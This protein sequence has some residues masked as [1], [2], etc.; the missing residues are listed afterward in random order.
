MKKRFLIVCFGL[1]VVCLTFAM[2]IFSMAPNTMQVYGDEAADVSILSSDGQ[3]SPQRS[4][5][6]LANE[7][8]DFSTKYDGEAL[9]SYYS[10]RDEYMLYAQQQS[11]QGLCW[12]FAS[13]M[14]LSTTIMKK[15]GE[16]LDFSE[17]W[18]SLAITYGTAS[19][20]FTEY[21]NNLSSSYYPGDG[22]WFLGFDL[23]AKRYGVLLEQEFSF[24]QSYLT[25]MSN[26]NS[27]YNEYSQYANKNIMQNVTAGKFLNYQNKDTATRNLTL[28][29][30]KQHIK[31]DGGV[32]IALRWNSM[33]TIN[34]NGKDL[35]FKTPGESTSAGHL[36][37]IIGWDDN[38]T[39]TYNGKTYKGAWIVLNSWGNEVY[40]TL[41]DRGI[42]YIF[43]DDSNLDSHLWAYEYN[44]T[45]TDDDLYLR[46]NIT[47]SNATYTTKHA[48]EYYGNFVA[49]SAET[50]QKNIFHNID[51]VN[52]VYEY[53][54]SSMTTLSKAEIFCK[55]EDVTNNFTV[56]YG[57]NS[58][59]ING[60]DVPLGAYQVVFTYTNGTTTEQAE[61]CFYV[62]D[63]TETNYAYYSIGA[64]AANGTVTN[65][66]KYLNYNNFNY[67]NE[68]YLFATSLSSG[69]L[70]FKLIFATY[71][72]IT[73]VT[74]NTSGLY[75]GTLKNEQIWGTIYFDLSTATT[76]S[77]TIRTSKGKTK[78]L[79]VKFV[80]KTNSTDEWANVFYETNGGKNNAQNER[81]ELVSSTTGAILE[82]PT[83]QGYN[84]AGW[85][86]DKE[87]TTKLPQSGGKYYIEKQMLNNTNGAVGW[88]MSDQSVYYGKQVFV[89]VYAKWTK[90]AP[91]GDC[92]KI[93]SGGVWNKY[94][95]LEDA[96]AAAADSDV[97]FLTSDYVLEEQIVLDKHITIV[98][99]N[100]A[101]LYMGTGV[102]GQE[103]IYSPFT[104]NLTLGSDVSTINGLTLTKL[105]ID[106]DS[107]NVS[108]KTFFTGKTFATHDN[109][110]VQNFKYTD[111]L[112]SAS[113]IKI[114]GGTIQDN[115]YNNSSSEI[116]SLCS[117]NSTI[118]ING[119]S[120]VINN[121]MQ[122]GNANLLYA[123]TVTL[124]QNITISGNETASVICVSTFYP[125]GAVIKNN[126]VVYG[127]IYAHSKSID[128]RN[129]TI[130]SEVDL[131]LGYTSGEVLVDSTTNISTIELSASIDVKYNIK[132]TGTLLSSQKFSILF[133]NNKLKA[134]YLIKDGDYPLITLENGATISEDNIKFVLNSK[135]PD[136]SWVVS[137][138]YSLARG[139]K[140]DTINNYYIKAI[141]NF[142]YNLNYTGATSV[143][144][145]YEFGET[146]T[147][148]EQPTRAG[149]EF[150]GWYTTSALTTLYTFGTMPASDVTVYAKW[151]QLTF[152][153]VAS[154]TEGGTITPSG[155]VNKRYNTRQK[156]LFSPSTGYEVKNI[157]VDGVALTGT[158]LTDAIA[159]GYTFKL[160]QADHTIHVEFVATVHTFTF[161]LNYDGSENI[162]QSYTY[163]QT[164]KKIA[165][166]S[167]TG[168]SFGGWYKDQACT[169]VY[170]FG[171]MPNKDVTVYAK[172]T[173]NG[174]TITA[175]VNG[176]NGTITPSGTISKNQGESQTFTFTPKTGY[177]VSQILV[178]GIELTQTQ[179]QDAIQNGY[180][181]ENI[182][183]SHT[184]SVSFTIYTYTF[185]YD[186]NYEGA[187]D[188]TRTYAYNERIVKISD[189]QR[190]GY[191]FENW[192]TDE[193]LTTTYTFARMPANDVTVYAKWTINSYTITTTVSGNGSISPNGKIT[194]IYG[195][196][197]TFTL[198]PQPGN[199]VG[200]IA[201]NGSTL[202]TDKT[203]DAI[204]NGLTIS[205]IAQNYTISVVF[206]AIS[207][208]FTFDLN[209]VGSQ[210]ITT[211]IKCGEMVA[212]IADPTRTG[213]TFGGWYQEAECINK[214][215]TVTMPANDITIYAKWTIKSYVVTATAGENGS[216]SPYGQNVLEF[217]ESITFTFTPDKGYCVKS[218]NI[219]DKYLSASELAN[220]IAYGYTFASVSDNHTIDVQFEVVAYT[221]VY[222]LNYQGGGEIS[223]NYDF[224]DKIIKIEDPVRD[225]YTFEG[226]YVE[227]ECLTQ[228][229]FS[230]MPDHDEIVYAKWTIKSYIITAT[231]GENGSITPSGE[232]QKLFGESVQFIF[233]AQQ[234]YCVQA[235][236]VD[237]IAL[238]QYQ[239]QTAITSGYKFEKI[240]DNH[241]IHV[242]F[243][244]NVFVLTYNLNYIGAEDIVKEVE[245]GETLEQ[246]VP[247]RD[248]YDFG[249]W[250]QEQQCLTP[251]QLS[252]MPNRDVTM[253]AKW[254]IKSYVITISSNEN[255]VVTPNGEITKNY[256]ESITIT[257]EPNYGFRL[258]DLIVDGSKLP[259]EQLESV[260]TNG[261]IFSDIKQNHNVVA[262]FVDARFS[263]VYDFNYEGIENITV[264]YLQ[265]ETIEKIADPTR[266]GYTF[267]GWYCEPNCVTKYDF[268][269]M[270]NRDVTIYAKWQSVTFNI[271]ATCGQNGEISPLGENIVNQGDDIIFIIVPNNGFEIDEVYIDGEKLVGVDFAN[272][273]KTRKYI[274]K[275]V[276]KDH[277]I[278]V[279]FKVLTYEIVATKSGNGTLS[280][281][282]T[283]QLFDK[284]SITYTFEPEIGHYISK[285]VIDGIEFFG[286]E[287][288][289]YTF[290]NV[291]EDHTIFVEFE[292]QKFKIEFE[293]EGNCRIN[294]D[295][296]LSE[297]AYGENRVIIIDLSGVTEIR[298]VT[299]DGYYVDIVDNTIVI[300]NVRK[301]II[302]AIKTAER[303]SLT[304]VFVVFIIIAVVV[305]GGGLIVMF[306]MLKRKPRKEELRLDEL[307]QQMEKYNPKNKQDK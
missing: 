273:A 10:M 236:Y 179:L 303:T 103:V 280:P 243:V 152:D 20:E 4:Y 146:V 81:M 118:T 281:L 229:Q 88:S 109:V 61:S 178:D 37:N 249:G 216:I 120:R 177:Y 289:K 252:T 114:N 90:K 51:D 78:N 172:W 40:E 254:T 213:Y 28:N 93:Y 86:Y 306:R 156:F 151:E 282:G 36:L 197:I 122:S 255:G 57:A 174:F 206:E 82:N 200:L 119:T 47:S 7:Y 46:Q 173:V 265:G 261:Y 154:A 275:N 83:K 14:S 19:G 31:N 73:S 2:G 71:N 69:T 66:K 176:S 166:P 203:Q 5:Y 96:I 124:S 248:G 139:T 111:T 201:I 279:S 94:K 115:I 222:N 217:G 129:V 239:M 11:S 150:M 209:Y 231:S 42:V 215:V 91:T 256:G 44:E 295:K 70:Q 107:S 190:T 208:N 168:Y 276:Q 127:T 300:E 299:I 251:C 274:F 211:K 286:L 264:K 110:F 25:S 74:P 102:D 145:N 167:R 189:P 184:I 170:N 272:V 113:Y 230:T 18:I 101:T 106:G 84:F 287:G 149:Y 143:V 227:S 258:G 21:R 52:L 219:D 97:I 304:T 242:E 194:K 117:A 105:T 39:G 108:I 245:V 80:R 15:T 225:G 49:K 296:N 98:S 142:T 95:K 53:T 205:D 297:V 193:T 307:K 59:G 58:V 164:I 147:P 135:A 8:A 56:T 137:D 223:Q 210:P 183:A 175:S 34:Y 41:G 72:E 269:V 226:W 277:S 65:N 291:V 67:Y 131:Y 186:L 116:N 244:Q 285:I 292:I 278:V 294:C 30:I 3:D 283:T 199:T 76:Y 214:F 187:K 161:D 240:S 77:F 305:G 9:P 224:G 6:S 100:N 268:G 181:F 157:V 45:I 50:K 24:E 1:L 220:A 64:N 134:D 298:S 159:N 293:I 13:N 162:T 85:Y 171:T 148:I 290:E 22:G 267:E 234:G 132:V 153:I 301:D 259:A 75:F 63:G 29:S 180:T 140:T 182:S 35:Y 126:S 262:E 284:Q 33:T 169:S 43:Y 232:I 133:G 204:E 270:P 302:I 185:T 196:S 89:H 16:F 38:I 218:I 68:E 26:Y 212:L 247:V 158:D 92:A 136:G 207:Y 99:D 221:F 253:F 121:T 241:T 238:D 257:F 246:F 263:F 54:T 165:N 125:N 155:T 27:L 141:F 163:G 202:S 192:Y 195:E 198:T 235:I 191:T 144:Q 55:G 60:T 188:I 228:Y 271:I 260:Q 17:G 87:L 128:M 160:I 123:N 237:D 48:G 266:K 62:C 130:E 32:T 12:C 288:N 104:Y 79:S 112:I 250:Y 233:I 23:A 138:T